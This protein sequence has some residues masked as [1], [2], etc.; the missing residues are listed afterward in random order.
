MLIALLLSQP[1]MQGRVRKID[2]DIILAGE[3][4]RKATTSHHRCR[5][6]ES[7]LV[8]MG[9]AG[10]KPQAILSARQNRDHARRNR[11]GARPLLMLF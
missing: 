11:K 1:P 2:H 6:A 10:V 3:Y 5:P 8:Q 4:A 7:A 9:A